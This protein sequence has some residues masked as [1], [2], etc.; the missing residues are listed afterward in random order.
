MASLQFAG[1]RLSLLWE[2]VV[3]SQSYLKG[4]HRRM[5][6]SRMARFKAWL[7]DPIDPY[8]LAIL[9][10]GYG[11]LM[12]YNMFRYFKIG[13]IRNMFVLPRVNFHY[14]FL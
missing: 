1:G 8:M 13:L 5:E 9:R 14:D 11:I 12:M 7:A 2:I 3:F 10:I 4:N 6:Q